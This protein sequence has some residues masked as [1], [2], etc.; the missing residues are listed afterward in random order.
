MIRCAKYSSPGGREYNEDCCELFENPGGI[1]AVLADGLGG[2]G[3]GQ[4]A[5]QTAVDTVRDR[6]KSQIEIDRNDLCEWFQAA[7]QA[8]LGKQTNSC[9][10][11][12]TMIVLC[13]NEE[14]AVWAHIGDSRLYQFINGKLN[15][16]TFDHSVTQMAVISGEITR[17]EMRQHPDRNRLLKALGKEGEIKAELSD[18]CDVS[19]NKQQFLLCSDGFWEYVFESEMEQMLQKAISP[20]EWIE[21]MRQ[22]LEA[23]VEGE[24]DNYSA[25]AIWVVP[26]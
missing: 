19:G 12:T 15:F 5:S 14:N 26:D 7:N 2:H 21:D 18:I 24:N 6:F 4:V 11:K 9:K 22:I 13:V 20:A 17:E 23:R 1:C 16:I 3:G 8:V 25:V 10:M